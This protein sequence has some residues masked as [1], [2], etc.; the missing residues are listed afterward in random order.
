MARGIVTLV[1]D[2]ELTGGVGI[3]VFDGVVRIRIDM[4]VAGYRLAT[5]WVPSEVFPRHRHFYHAPASVI[6]DFVLR[7]G[8]DPVRLGC[9]S[10][11]DPLPAGLLRTSQ[12]R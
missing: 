8:V 2:L 6:I 7:Q 5:G 12:V 10:L 1:F 9:Q 4:V 3:Q 11:P